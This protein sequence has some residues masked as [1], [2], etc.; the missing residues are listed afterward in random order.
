MNY[1]GHFFKHDIL[2]KY[3][4]ITEDRDSKN[5]LPTVVIDVGQKSISNDQIY[6]KYL[7]EGR[8]KEYEEI[9]LEEFMEIYV[10][11]RGITECNLHKALRANETHEP[12]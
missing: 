11:V 5:F 10:G 1:A 2:D 9:S 8:N 3:I 12:V 6:I 4:A 7:E